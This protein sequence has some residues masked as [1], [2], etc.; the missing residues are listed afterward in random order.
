MWICDSHQSYIESLFLHL[1]P[2]LHERGSRVG[3][4]WSVRVERLVAVTDRVIDELGAVLSVDQLQRLPD[5]LQIVGVC[6][7]G[8]HLP[9]EG[10]NRKGV[11]PDVAAHVY[12][13]MN[14]RDKTS[15]HMPRNV[16]SGNLERALITLSTIGF[17]H[18]PWCLIDL[19]IT[20][21]D[22]FIPF[23]NCL[24]QMMVDTSVQTIQ[25]LPGQV[26]HDLK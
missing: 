14:S 18:A 22:W 6:V 20:V 13:R 1:Q 10:S 2:S 5:Q 24:M 26:C 8:D 21:S 7:H 17:S 4:L 19:L 25:T 3:R 11:L 12:K 15:Q 23:P 16:A 9:S